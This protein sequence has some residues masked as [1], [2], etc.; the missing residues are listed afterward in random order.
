[1]LELALDHAQAFS[2]KVFEHLC[3]THGR[4]DTGEK[5]FDSARVGMRASH[6]F[7]PASSR[8]LRFRSRAFREIFRYSVSK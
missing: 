2:I 8:S 3:V 6:I 7:A 1:M 5:R 4:L